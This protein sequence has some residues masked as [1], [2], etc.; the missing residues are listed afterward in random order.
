MKLN[1]A[2]LFAALVTAKGSLAAVSINF[3][4]AST[5]WVADSTNL[6]S[7]TCRVP[8]APS[9][10][11]VVVYG[12]GALA[13]GLVI[14]GPVPDVD[15]SIITPANGDLTAG[16][17]YQVAL[18]DSANATD[19]VAKSDV[20]TIKPE[21]SPYAPE[22]SNNATTILPTS[23]GGS[24]STTASSSSPT[25]SKTGKNAASALSPGHLSFSAAVALV[26]S[27]LFA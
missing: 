18:V 26:F 24:S 9:Q 22:P 4:S 7:W 1:A 3:P 10:Y 6:L 5:W 23:T 21:G 8:G 14:L 15:C 2:A 16:S 25:S 17:N 19:I 27:A 20:F 12:P 13:V 11:N